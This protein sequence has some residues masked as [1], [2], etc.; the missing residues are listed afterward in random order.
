[1]PQVSVIIPVLNESARIACALKELQ[2]LRVAGVEL[3]VVDGGS[4]DATAADAH[5]LADQVLLSP[6]GRARQM[7]AGAAHASGEILLFLHA[8]TRLPPSALPEILAAIHGARK[9][10]RFDVQIAGR[11][12]WLPVIAKLMN[13]RSR[14]TGIATGD[15][16]IF[17]SRDTFN[18][19]GG[20]PDMPLMEDI[21]LS[22]KLRRL[23]PP[24][25][26]ATPVIT[27]GRRWDTNGSLQTIFL[28]WRLRLRFFLGADPCLLAK[29]YGYAPR[30]PDNAKQP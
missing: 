4:T 17:V 24:I 27:S 12:A 22:D 3:I 21:A 11:S 8:D 13:W 10:G 14:L 29:E 6:C 16:A 15:Q 7:N 5:G 18:A 19:V 1:M 20:Y 23:S 26:I 9:W 30:A 28:M 2:P 25:C